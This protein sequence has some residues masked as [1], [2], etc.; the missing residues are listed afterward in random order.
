MLTYF[1]LLAGSLTVLFGM[2]AENVVGV[3]DPFGT[4]FFSI[5]TLFVSYSMFMMQDHNTPEYIDFLRVIKRYKCTLCFCCFGSMVKEQYRI[6]VDEADER[7]VNKGKTISTRKTHNLSDDMEYGN[8]VTGMEMS[9]ATRTSC[10]VDYV[11]MEDRPLVGKH[12]SP[13]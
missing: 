6:L 4:W 8:N 5:W 9:I 12:Q 3:A 1:Y 2:A 10:N 7:T 13:I 11:I